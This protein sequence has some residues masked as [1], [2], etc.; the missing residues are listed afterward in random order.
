M[1]TRNNGAT[2]GFVSNES[3]RGRWNESLIR[4]QSPCRLSDG[5]KWIKV[6]SPCRTDGLAIRVTFGMAR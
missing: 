5:S 1:A 4:L 3:V 2:C 6:A